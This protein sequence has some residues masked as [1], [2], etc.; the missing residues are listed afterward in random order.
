M[1]VGE[2]N[3]K[4]NY[5]RNMVQPCQSHNPWILAIPFVNDT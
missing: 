3:T 4:E 5:I 2:E 1:Y